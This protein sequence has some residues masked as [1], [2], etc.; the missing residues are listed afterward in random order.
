[1]SEPQHLS[2]PIGAW[3][4]EHVADWKRY[5]VFAFVVALL[6]YGITFVMPRWYRA[7]VVMLPPEE[8]DQGAK[9]SQSHAH[10]DAQHLDGEAA[11]EP[12][13]VEEEALK[14]VEP[15]EL[16]LFLDHDR[17]DREDEPD[18][19]GHVAE[20]ASEVGGHA[21]FGLVVAHGGGS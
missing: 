9:P 14:P 10:H 16:V 18:A 11:H 8:A 15:H 5:L 19:A 12:D 21:E 17:D 2:V 13:S 4:Q 6:G 3:L 7:S 20:E 1:M